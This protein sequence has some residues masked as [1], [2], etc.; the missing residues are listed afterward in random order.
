LKANHNKAI[1][2]R[3]SQALRTPWGF[4]LFA[5]KLKIINLTPKY[6]LE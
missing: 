1:S 6:L 3:F 2:R 4:I 5:L